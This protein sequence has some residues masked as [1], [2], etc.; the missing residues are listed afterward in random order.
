MQENNTRLID[1]ALSSESIKNTFRLGWEFITLNK[2]F[3][4]ISLAIAVGTHILSYVDESLGFF[5]MLF[6]GFYMIAVQIE[7]GKIVHNTQNIETF[8][9]EVKAVDAL[10]VVRI[11]AEQVIGA[12]I[13]WSLVYIGIMVLFIV[14][15]FMA[16]ALIGSME[17]ALAFTLIPATVLLLFVAYLQPLIQAKIALSTNLEEAMFSVFA[18]VKPEFR[19]RAF[20]KSYFKYVAS[21]LFVLLAIPFAL[22][23]MQG[24][25]LFSSVSILNEVLMVLLPIAVYVATVIMAVGYMMA[26]RMVEKS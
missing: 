11:H 3:T 20:N 9:D 24:L 26:S 22:T 15:G 5:L 14:M 7:V 2:Q 13:G 16:Y 6:Y 18:I 1:E 4:Y 25:G 23:T 19:Q 10:K 21:L 17:E 12:V 8:I